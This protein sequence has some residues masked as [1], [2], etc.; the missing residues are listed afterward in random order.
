M[1]FSIRTIAGC[2]VLLISWAN[3]D[4]LAFAASQSQPPVNQDAK[5]LADFKARVDAYVAVH[6]KVAKGLPE[7]SKEGTPQEIDRYQRSLLAGIAAARAGAKPGDVFT[8]PIQRTIK[9]LIARAFAAGNSKTL[10][11]S[12]QD[13]NPGPVRLTINGAYPEAVPLA[14]MP[15][16][17]LKNLP[18]LPEIVEYRFVG[19][20]LILL[21]S[22][23]HLVVDIIPGAMPK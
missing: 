15:A 12:I 4:Q 10:R 6:Q 23:A 21:D 16:E 11:E 17:L 19:E 5:S 2:A 7:L 14:N 13:E 20:S 18:P 3:A 8:P 22:A 9:A 1:S